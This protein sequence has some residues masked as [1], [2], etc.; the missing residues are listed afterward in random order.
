MCSCWR[1]TPLLFGKDARI[2]DLA[3]IPTNHAYPNN[4]GDLKFHYAGTNSQDS[5]VRATLTGKVG[6]SRDGFVF[7]QEA[8]TNQNGLT[9]G[10]TGTGR[11]SLISN[12]SRPS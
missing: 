6:L 12:C 10:A 11:H 5:S 9:N 3:G 1:L 8:E 2:F 4:T 7:T